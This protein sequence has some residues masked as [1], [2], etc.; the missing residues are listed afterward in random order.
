MKLYETIFQLCENK[1]ISITALE[2]KLGL[3][4]GLI[5]KWKNGTSPNLE[6]LQKIADYFH[7]TIDYL[8]TGK[9]PATDWQP[10]LTEKDEMDIAKQLEKT[11]NDL[12]SDQEGLMFS[13][14]PL[15]DETKELLRISLENSMRLAKVTA[16]EKFTPN[17]YRK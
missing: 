16:K 12:E 8:T 5:G 2:N 13:G 4:R 10:T 6:K 15:D 9:A 14:E 7:V 17:K 11:L 1:N 3:G